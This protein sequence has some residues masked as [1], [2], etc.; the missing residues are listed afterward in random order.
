MNSKI[1]IKNLIDVPD[2][3]DKVGGTVTGE[4]IFNKS[5]SL[6]GLSSTEIS[7]SVS[8]AYTGKGQL[9]YD[10]GNKELVIHSVDKIR[11]SSSGD[12]VY[13]TNYPQTS[14]SG[15]A[16]TATKLQTPRTINGTSFDG[17][18]DINTLRWGN[19]K[20]FTIGNASKSVNGQNDVSWS[21]SEIGAAT[22]THDHNDTYLKLSGGTLSGSL[23]CYDEMYTG[24]I[25]SNNNKGYSIQS[26]SGN[27]RN[28]MTMNPA[29]QIILGDNNHPLLVFSSDN[30]KYCPTSSLGYYFYHEGNKPTPDEIGAIPSSKIT[31]SL[32]APSNPTVGDLWISW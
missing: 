18:S 10:S 14:V 13:S 28:L 7:S 1:A 25:V 29:N 23:T 21:L 9:F 30:P 20:T 27:F 19:T 22:N 8:T 3:F 11:L 24:K 26:S 16:G 15:N 17:S 31:I 6:K 2:K 4:T 5:L 32:T 12:L